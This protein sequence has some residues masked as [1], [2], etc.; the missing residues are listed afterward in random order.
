MD[1]YKQINSHLKSEP[2]LY[3]PCRFATSELKIRTDCK[4]FIRLLTQGSHGY[5]TKSQPHLGGC[6]NADIQTHPQTHRYHSDIGNGN[7]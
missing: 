1:K 5:K 6:V 7:T 2:F 4:F 3:F